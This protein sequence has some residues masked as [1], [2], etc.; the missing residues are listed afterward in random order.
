MRVTQV[1]VIDII[2]AV[3]YIVAANPV[4][5]GLLIHE[6]V[7]LGVLVIFVV[8]AAQH[9]DW[10]IDTLK[11]LRH[12]TPGQIA[13]L[14]LDTLT[15]AMFMVVVVSGG[16]VSRHILPMLGL[17]APG[18]FFWNPLHSLSAKVLLA[19]LIVHIVVHAKWLWAF[20]KGFRQR[21]SHTID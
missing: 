21:K 14:V 20:V 12:P 10:I 17:V 4:M 7:S 1:L 18:Y 16:M 9:Y 11:K 2:A 6:W 8:H 3:L 13:N 15:V 19:L 5:T